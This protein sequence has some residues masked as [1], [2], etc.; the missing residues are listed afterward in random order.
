MQLEQKFQFV[1]SNGYHLK[2]AAMIEKLR[3]NFLNA[4]EKALNNTKQTIIPRLIEQ[5]RATFS[6][7]FKGSEYPL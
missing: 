2:P 4:N 6:F 5:F 3:P 1:F 7:S